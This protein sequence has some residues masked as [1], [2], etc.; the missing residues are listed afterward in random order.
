[1]ERAE[2]A[3]MNRNDHTV[4]L[5]NGR[6]A[7]RKIVHLVTMPDKSVCG[8]MA[9]KELKKNTYIDLEGLMQRTKSNPALMLEVITLYLEQI[10]PLIG[11]MRKSLADDDWERLYSAAHK[12]VPSFSIMGIDPY[13]ENL[14]KKIQEYAKSRQ[15]TDE[16][17]DLVL[18][19]EKMCDGVYLEL[20]ETA[21]TLKNKNP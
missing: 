9:K 17:S 11:I 8:N 16:L 18:Q 1:M 14:A 15:H 12:M 20:T 19:L 21:N 7:D 3:T 13:Y 10:P 6:L 2:Q 4:W 5:A